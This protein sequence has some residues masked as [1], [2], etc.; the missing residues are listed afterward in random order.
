VPRHSQRKHVPDVRR[1]PNPL[2]RGL[3]A[4]LLLAVPVVALACVRFPQVGP[5]LAPLGGEDDPYLHGL[6]ITDRR[7]AE[8]RAEV[9]GIRLYEGQDEIAALLND[10]EPADNPTYFAAR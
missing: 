5:D 2:V 6:R 4:A 7:V 9:G 10:W 8:R 3:A 1:P